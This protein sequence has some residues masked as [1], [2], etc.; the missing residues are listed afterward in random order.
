MIVK[1]DVIIAE[2]FI[3]ITKCVEKTA[4]S[5]RDISRL[6]IITTGNSH[7]RLLVIGPESHFSVTKSLQEDIECLG[8]SSGEPI[9]YSQVHAWEGDLPW[10]IVVQCFHALYR[11]F[12]TLFCMRIVVSKHVSAT[13]LVE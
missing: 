7:K 12:K 11:L 13:E 9:D 5:D 3:H 6:I 8:V 4:G 2:R 1:A 10:L